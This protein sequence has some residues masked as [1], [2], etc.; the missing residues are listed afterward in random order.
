MVEN[1]LSSNTHMYY[2]I[3]YIFYRL[4]KFLSIEEQYIL[5]CFERIDF[6][7]RKPSKVLIESYCT[8]SVPNGKSRAQNS[9]FEA[10]W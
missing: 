6:N 5:L 10:S 8:V 3:L 4:I 7:F 1:T 2:Y 9:T